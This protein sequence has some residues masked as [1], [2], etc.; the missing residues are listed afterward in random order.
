MGVYMRFLR[1]GRVLEAT[2]IG[3]ALVL[4]AV[5]GGPVGRR[6]RPRWAPVFT[7]DRHRRSRSR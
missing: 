2:A 6:T 4:L 3:L 5:V 7:L 1:P